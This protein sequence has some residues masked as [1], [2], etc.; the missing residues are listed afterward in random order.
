MWKRFLSDNY[1]VSISE[2]GIES[3][4]IG[5]MT[6]VLHFFFSLWVAFSTL[7]FFHRV[8][9]RARWSMEI[10]ELKIV[11]AELNE[12]VADLDLA[13]NELRRYFRTL[14]YYDRFRKFDMDGAGRT[15]DDSM[16]GVANLST[17]ASN[18]SR[19]KPIL[20]NIAKNLSLLNGEME[21]RVESLGAILKL[22]RLNE[23]APSG[24]VS[25]LKAGDS[26]MT[27]R[28]VYNIGRLGA[29]ESRLDSAPITMPMQDCRISSHYGMRLDPFSKK[30]KLH[31]GI[32]LVGPYRSNV[33]AP[34]GGRVVAIRS[35]KEMGNVVSLDHGNGII[36]TYGHLYRAH[37]TVGQRVERG[38][39]IATQGASGLRST[40][41]H[42]HY[43]INVRNASQDP[44][45]FIRVG[46]LL[47]ISAGEKSK[48][49]EAIVY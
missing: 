42:V 3:R 49:S 38:E 16:L 21:L 6:R 28:V 30:M 46:K 22:V 11:N 32:D 25:E 2:V 36:T 23:G 12:K 5:P 44:N 47:D 35:S 29:L 26:K 10:Y 7:F 34:A 41:A 33:L 8:R 18:Y 15:I 14:N 39:A 4:K 27:S 31:N 45:N 40:G 37:V 19:A 48:K 43:E 13:V 1:V 20:A 24:E 9:K 17:G